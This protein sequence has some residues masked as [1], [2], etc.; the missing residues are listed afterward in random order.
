[1][2][3]NSEFSVNSKKIHIDIDPSNIAKNVKIGCPLSERKGGLKRNDW[4]RQ[5]CKTM[6]AFKK[7]IEP[8]WEQIN[9]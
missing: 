5:A 4:P 3:E 6:D 2:T 9:Q 7:Q 1:V 8:W